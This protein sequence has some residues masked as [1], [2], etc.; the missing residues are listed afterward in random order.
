MFFSCCLTDFV[1]FAVLQNG[2]REILCD[3]TLM[4]IDIGRGPCTQ[5]QDHNGDPHVKLGDF[6]FSKVVTAMDKP[7][8]IAGTHY[9]C[10]PEIVD[11]IARNKSGTTDWSLDT[12]SLGMLIF[13]L[14]YGAAHDRKH[15][16]WVMAH[17]MRLDPLPTALH[18]LATLPRCP[19]SV[20]A[21]VED[22]IRQDPTQRPSVEQMKKNPL[23]DEVS[24]GSGAGLHKFPWAGLRAGRF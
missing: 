20:V 10:A 3:G 21:L 5:P 9:F 14:F 11:M 6:G 17:H 8:S 16:K 23:F 13:V 4:W 22:S 18:E 15:D 12:Y 24:L 2:G 7:V 19:E 1:D